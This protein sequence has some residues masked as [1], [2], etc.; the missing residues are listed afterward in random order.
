MM[1]LTSHVGM[2][3]GFRKF[4]RISGRALGEIVVNTS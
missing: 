4:S 1:A 2:G 3:R